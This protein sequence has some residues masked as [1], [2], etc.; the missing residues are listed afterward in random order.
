M[1][2]DRLRRAF[3]WSGLVALVC[4]FIGFVLA[5]FIPPPSPSWTE[6]AVADHYRIHATGIRTGMVLMT[7]SGMFFLPFVGII[8]EQLRRIPRV[9][10][11]IV[12]TQ[13]C[14]GTLNAVFFVIPPVLFLVTAFRPDRPPEITYML[15]DL[16]W[17]M[18]IIPWPPAFMQSVMI[19][20][21][22]LNDP[23]PAPILP[24]WLGFLNLWVALAYVPSS[25]LV[26]FKSGPF[27]WNGIFVFW[28]AGSVF[29]LWFIAMI[30]TLLKSIDP[31]VRSP[32]SASASA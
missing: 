1:S 15:N 16:S 24:R 25:L 21:A 5:R 2:G 13:L 26:F 22:V 32:A 9:P 3:C 11:S 19:A 14:A 20:I 30:A 6:A 28:L 23:S 17:I 12:Y 10:I 8:S 29:S 18:A 7:V 27:A 31:E 4:F